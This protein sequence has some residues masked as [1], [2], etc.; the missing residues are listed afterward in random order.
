MGFY[1]NIAMIIGFGALGVFV[2]SRYVK[3]RNKVIV[4][5]KMW[6]FS[7]TTLGMIEILALIT[8]LTGDRSQN[9]ILDYIRVVTMIVACTA[10]MFARDGLAEE[11]IVHNSKMIPWN[12]IRAWDKHETSKQIELYF[13]IDSQNPKKPD[14]YKTIE[15]DFDV[16]NK[17]AVDR[18]LR[19]NVARKKTRM[20][21]K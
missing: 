15:M 17:E 13:T 16:A 3:V 4:Q 1:I 5:D 12:I 10:Y 19:L 21:R 6:S 8:L 18:F 20:K 11:G 9:D 2:I 14:T 7:R